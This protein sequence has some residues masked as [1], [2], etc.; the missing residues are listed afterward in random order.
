MNNYRSKAE[1]FFA[2]YLETNSIK[3]EYENF[4][5]PYV[6]TKH[7]YPDF[8][9]SDYNFFVEYKG[10]FKPSD[11]GKHLLFK[12]Q[13]PNIDIR[14]V[15]QNARNKINKKS[16]TTYGDWCDRHG[17]IWAEGTIPKSWLRKNKKLK[18]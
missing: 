5:I 12:Q 11:R 14:F 9:I 10:Y 6:I 17:F 1:Q 3:F 18:H 16:K 7:Y 8:F 13:H 4:S 2:E 15:F